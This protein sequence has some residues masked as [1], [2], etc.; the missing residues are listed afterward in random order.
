ME[1]KNEVNGEFK[2]RKIHILLKL[3]TYTGYFA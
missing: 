1:Q 3:N 2:G